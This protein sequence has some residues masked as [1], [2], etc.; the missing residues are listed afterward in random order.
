MITCPVCGRA[1]DEPDA[2]RC[3]GCGS[4]R[5]LWLSLAVATLISWLIWDAIAW[6]V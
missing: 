5:G 4:T 6:V 3:W 1:L 2:P